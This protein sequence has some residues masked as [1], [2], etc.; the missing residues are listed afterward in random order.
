MP[1]PG[2]NSEWTNLMP[3][4]APYSRD[5]ITGKL[6]PPPML[7]D[8]EIELQPR[9][10]GGGFFGGGGGG[11]GAPLDPNEVVKTLQRGDK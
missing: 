8:Y 2:T 6:R 3:P 1:D 9:G 4:N 11:G 7:E 10:G 5:P